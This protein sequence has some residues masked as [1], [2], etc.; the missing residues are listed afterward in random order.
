MPRKALVF[1]GYGLLE[2]LDF[3]T[4]IFPPLESPLPPD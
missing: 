3:Y 2:P 1:E 4:N